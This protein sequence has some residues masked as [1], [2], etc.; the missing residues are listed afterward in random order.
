MNWFIYY[1]QHIPGSGKRYWYDVG[2]IKGY[3]DSYDYCEFS[4]IIDIH[5]LKWFKQN[6]ANILI[7]WRKLTDEDIEALKD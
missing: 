5:P 2:G 3:G 1:K 4:Q 7:D 6:P